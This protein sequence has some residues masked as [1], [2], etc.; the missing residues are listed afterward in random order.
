MN[1][2]YWC[3][4]ISLLLLSFVGFCNDSF[5]VVEKYTELTQ[6]VKSIAISDDGLVVAA[7]SDDGNIAIYDCTEYPSVSCTH[8][9][10]LSPGAVG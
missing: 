7:S 1:K 10:N 3:R 6:T 4:T 2:F 5:E 8:A 9:E